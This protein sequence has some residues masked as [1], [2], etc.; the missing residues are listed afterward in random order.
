MGLTIDPMGIETRVLHDL[1]DYSGKD[2][3]EIGWRRTNDSPFCRADDVRHGFRSRR[4]H[5]RGC[6][7]EHSQR[8]AI[9]DFF[10]S[11]RYYHRRVAGDRLRCRGFFWVDMMNS[12][13]ERR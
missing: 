10:S 11:R 5:D 7:G 4:S 13:R 9:G 6:E 1:I 3:L 12:S 2:V 8:E